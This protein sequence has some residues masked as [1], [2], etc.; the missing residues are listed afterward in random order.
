MSRHAA[1]KGVVLKSKE[2]EWSNTQL[3]VEGNEQKS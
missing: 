2:A 1:H 3:Q